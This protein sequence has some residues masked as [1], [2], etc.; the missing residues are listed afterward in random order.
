MRHES[1]EISPNYRK[2]TISKIEIRDHPLSGEISDR[3][4]QREVVK[5]KKIWIFPTGLEVHL[6]DMF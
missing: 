4:A 6:E 1:T 3:Q 5:I 2:L